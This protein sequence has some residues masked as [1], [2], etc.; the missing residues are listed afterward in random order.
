MVTQILADMRQSILEESWNYG[1]GDS[2]ERT[3][4]FTER[5]SGHRPGSLGATAKHGH[6][7]YL[8]RTAKEPN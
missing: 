2:D 5:V 6:P 1:S 4:R 3:A 7:A 8:L